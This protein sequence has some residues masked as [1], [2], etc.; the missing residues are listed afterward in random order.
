MFS[1]IVNIFFPSFMSLQKCVFCFEKLM[2]F[3]VMLLQKYVLPLDDSFPD[4]KL[5]SFVEKEMPWYVDF[6]NYFSAGDLPPDMN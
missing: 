2:E 3:F 1:F 4:D 5:F 6:F